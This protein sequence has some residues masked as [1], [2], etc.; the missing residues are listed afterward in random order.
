MTRFSADSFRDTFQM[1]RSSSVILYGKS[2]CE[3]RMEDSLSMTLHWRLRPSFMQSHFETTTFLLQSLSDIIA[4]KASVINSSA[5]LAR[6]GYTSNKKAL[7]GCMFIF[8]VL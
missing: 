8:D 6:L 4:I 2:W 1:H 5:G 3:W 7:N